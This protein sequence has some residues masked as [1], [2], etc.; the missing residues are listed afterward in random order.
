MKPTPFPRKMPKQDISSTTSETGEDPSRPYKCRLCPKAFHRLEHQIRHTRTHTGE[1]PYS[2]TFP[3]CLKRFSRSDELTRHTRTHAATKLKRGKKQLLPSTPLPHPES[4]ISKSRSFMDVVMVSPKEEALDISRDHFW[5]T[6]PSPLL[7]PCV[8]P[9]S[10]AVTATLNMHRVA[11]LVA[12]WPTSSAMVTQTRDQCQRPSPPAST[13]SSPVSM[14]MSDNESDITVSPLFT[15]ESSPIPTISLP[16][17][18][19]RSSSCG[20]RVDSL[21][22]KFS[23]TPESLYRLPAL[24]PVL[25][26]PTQLVTLPPISTIMNSIVL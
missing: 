12:I 26:E 17:S 13:N 20:I 11:S 24:A 5:S 15:P 21:C 4:D 25:T 16:A 3:T 2:C 8:V 22:H 6:L 9:S 10:A 19:L 14:A 18:A 23:E 7:S 1:R